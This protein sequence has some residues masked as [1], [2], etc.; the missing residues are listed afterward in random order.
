MWV[1]LVLLDI[2][3]IIDVTKIY[4][5][6][7]YCYYY[8]VAIF[9]VFYIVIIIKTNF[10]VYGYKLSALHTKDYKRTDKPYRKI[11]ASI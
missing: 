4:Y 8:D 2:H 5:S 9:T 11:N 7:L 1:C 10:T 6:L 3:N